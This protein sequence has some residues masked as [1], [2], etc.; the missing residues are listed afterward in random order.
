MI[1][2]P[3]NQILNDLMIDDAN[4]RKL[5]DFIDLV[6]DDGTTKKSKALVT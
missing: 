4:T 2:L 3:G 1:E 6:I 5:T